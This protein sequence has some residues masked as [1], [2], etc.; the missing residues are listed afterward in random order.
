MSEL[1]QKITWNIITHKKAVDIN[2]QINHEYEGYKE[3]A[4]FYAN[5]ENWRRFPI[6][7]GTDANGSPVEQWMWIG[8]GGEFARKTRDLEPS[9]KV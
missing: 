8:D 6:D 7:T 3:I 5:P 9:T 4:E 2:N 1:L